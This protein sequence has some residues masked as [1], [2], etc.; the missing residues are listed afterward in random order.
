MF[1]KNWFIL[2]PRSRGLLPSDMQAQGRKL[3]HMLGLAVHGL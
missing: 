1:Y 3:M 2:D